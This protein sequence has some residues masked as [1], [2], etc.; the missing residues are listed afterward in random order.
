MSY[1]SVVHVMTSFR[2]IRY[3]YCEAT[4]LLQVNRSFL[5]HP[6]GFKRRRVL[7]PT[8][9]SSYWSG[10]SN[11]GVRTVD[12]TSQLVSP[13]LE[14]QNTGYSVVEPAWGE[15]FPQSSYYTSE[16]VCVDNHV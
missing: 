9:P 16:S 1:V 5:S 12:P 4:N 2:K 7:C 3:V 6:G 11:L 10:P 15:V 13:H 14:L 8:A